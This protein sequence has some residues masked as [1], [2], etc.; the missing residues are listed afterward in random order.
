[1]LDVLASQPAR[2]QP[3]FQQ[4]SPA[5]L[6]RHFRERTA[7]SFFPGFEATDATAQRHRDLFPDATES[8][9]KSSRLLTREH[10]WSL[11]GFGE[12]DFGG[13]IDWHRDP[14]SGRIWPLNYHAD[15]PL[16]HNDGSDVRVLWELNRLG[17][18]VTLGGAYSLTKDEAFATE[19][20]SQL[21]NWQRQNPVAR[22]A[23]WS[24]AMEVALRVMNLLAVFHLFR[25]SGELNEERL[26][27]WLAM[28]DQHGAHIRRNLEFSHLTTSNHYLSD[29]VGLLWLGTMLPE[30]AAANEWRSWA[31]GEM[32]RELDKQV[33][34]DGVDYESSTAYHCFVLELFLYSFVLC[35]SNGITIQDSYWRRLRAMLEYLRAILRPDGFVPLVGDADGGQVL[36]IVA[37]NANDRAYLLALGAAVFDDSQLKLPG[38]K[39]SPELLWLL[40]Q[41]GVQN[42]E[43][44]EYANSEQTSQA[45]PDAGTYVLRQ[46][47][48]YLLFNAN[49]AR[50]DRPASH[51]HND[52]LSIEV[53]AGGRAFLV[54]PGS[55]VYTA[56]LQERQLFRSTAY[57]STIQLDDEEQQT[58]NQDEPFRIGAEARVRVLLWETSNSHDR[59]VAEH[60]GYERLS[61]PVHRRSVTFD[62]I[63]RWWSIEDELIGSGNHSVVVRFHFDADLEVK[64][65]EEKSA[66]AKGASGQ[67]L[68]ICLLSPSDNLQLRLEPQF[69]S[70]HYGEKF[71]SITACWTIQTDL[72]CQLRWGIVPVG[73]NDDIGERLRLVQAVRV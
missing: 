11:L 3:K 18:L 49:G 26:L 73:P 4:F 54:D 61:G 52:A 25:D 34:P 71:P 58:I 32:L 35:R 68:V 23:N 20:F 69:V 38:Q 33:L 50:D 9:L 8:L 51:R 44:L 72:P 36:P 56:N 16:W 17:H 22:G 1:M 31:L 27:M 57:H 13:E 6:L 41:E 10:R 29:V 21:E 64:V 39:T 2:L 53:S 48:L 43:Q 7:P 24:C 59:V 47:D 60:V 65:F 45:F 19:C 5:D 67:Q 62:K 70:R 66:L 40:G 63:D 12:Q 37:H 42:Y 55:H 14:L 15:I 30:L 46:D 28:F